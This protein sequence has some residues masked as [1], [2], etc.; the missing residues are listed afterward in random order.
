MGARRDAADR[1]RLT[2]QA[3]F[4]QSDAA[5]MT[6]R[7]YS[8]LRAVPTAGSLGL[9][10]K[11]GSRRI[12]GLDSTT[13]FC[14]PRPSTGILTPRERSLSMARWT[15][16]PKSLA[17]H[18]LPTMVSVPVAGRAGER[19]EVQLQAGVCA[20]RLSLAVG[21]H[22]ADAVAKERAHL[23][24]QGRRAGSHLCSQVG[25]PIIL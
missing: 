14:A 24:W 19:V 8:A 22:D 1:A 3:R 17:P 6:A 2:P 11:N 7:A 4:S 18:R 20:P 25:V 23:D 16:S 5:V 9:L 13:T 21:P 12:E 15:C 10:P